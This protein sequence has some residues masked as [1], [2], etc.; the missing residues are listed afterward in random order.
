MFSPLKPVSYPSRYKLS[1]R[2]GGFPMRIRT[3]EGTLHVRIWGTAH[4]YI[5]LN[6]VPLPRALGA[7]QNDS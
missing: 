4:Q 5:Y 1:N 2:P 6:A 7:K 3:A